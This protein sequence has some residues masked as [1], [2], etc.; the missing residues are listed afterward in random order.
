MPVHYRHTFLKTPVI[1]SSSQS[2]VLARTKTVR[3]YCQNE[4]TIL[5]NTTIGAG[6]C[7]I[8][9]G[10]QGL[11]LQSNDLELET[12]HWAEYETSL[13]TSLYGF[14]AIPKKGLKLSG[15]RCSRA[16]RTRAENCQA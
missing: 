5:G 11:G 14:Q 7:E 9:C 15:G 16:T 6:L 1:R 2:L 4:E 8:I 12:L 13:E 3:P 10:F